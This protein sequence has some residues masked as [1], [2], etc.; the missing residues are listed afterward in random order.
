MTEVLDMANKG[1][2]YLFGDGEYKGNPIHGADLAAF[3]VSHLDSR[4]V[5]LDVGGPELMT[6]NEIAKAAFRAAGKPPKIT[7]IP[8]WIRNLTLGLIRF[9][10]GQKI[11]GPIE[12]FMTVM[13]QDM[14]A[15][16]VGQYHLEEY[17]RSKA[18]E[19]YPVSSS[20]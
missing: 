16:K 19:T 10:T 8:I 14:L 7:H 17:Y 5:E 2:V 12:F 4:E 13:T 9:F 20:N 18:K 15:P 1:K 11:Y 6:Q 3:M